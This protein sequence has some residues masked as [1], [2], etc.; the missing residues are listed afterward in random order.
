M[1]CKGGCENYCGCDGKTTWKEKL[2]FFGFFFLACL[3]TMFDNHLSFPY[4]VFSFAVVVL[5]RTSIACV[6]YFCYMLQTYL[7]NNQKIVPCPS[8]SWAAMKL[9]KIL[10]AIPLQFLTQQVQRKKGIIQEGQLNQHFLLMPFFEKKFTD[11]STAYS[12]LCQVADTFAQDKSLKSL[13]IAIAEVS[14]LILKR[15]KYI[16]AEVTKNK[17]KT[18]VYVIKQ[19]IKREEEGR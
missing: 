7:C 14:L 18:L 5:S 4:F 17:N 13:L 12:A 3:V 1:C 6:L 16:K 8:L 2:V 9:A 19:R 10:L 11:S 15:E